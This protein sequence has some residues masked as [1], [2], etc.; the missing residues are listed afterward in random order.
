M[1]HPP[2]APVRLLIVDSDEDLRASLAQHFRQAGASVTEAGTG[3][4]A[5]QKVGPARPDVALLDLNLPDIDG[6]Q[7]MARL[8]EAR[9]EVEVLLLA[10]H[11]S[12]ESAVQAM[13]SGAYD[14]L[15]RPFRL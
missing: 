14:Y 15:T 1:S 11:S 7:L 9:P 4:E 2:G 12:V 5:Q 13:R 6:L 10:A 8:K 3:Q